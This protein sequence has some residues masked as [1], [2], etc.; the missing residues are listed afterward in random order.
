MILI[1]RALARA[2]HNQEKCCITGY[3]CGS[4][5]QGALNPNYITLIKEGNSAGS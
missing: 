1:M 4:C 3:I 5:E 2:A